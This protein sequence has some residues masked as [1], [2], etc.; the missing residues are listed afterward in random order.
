MG[1]CGRTAKEEGH[2]GGSMCVGVA[3]YPVVLP[4]V[5]FAYAG[6]HGSER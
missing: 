1:K 3:P 6:A 4:A 2:G 5:L